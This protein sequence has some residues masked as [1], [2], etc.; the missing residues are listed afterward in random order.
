M[1]YVPTTP[2]LCELQKSQT[3]VTTVGLKDSRVGV[4]HALKSYFQLSQQPKQIVGP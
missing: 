1:G 2:H 4:Q 3:L